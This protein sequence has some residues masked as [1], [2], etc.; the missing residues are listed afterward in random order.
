[1][2][3]ILELDR[4]N[5]TMPV[6]PR[7]ADCSA[8]LTLPP[9]QVCSIR[10]TPGS[11]KTFTIAG[12][13]AEN[14]CGLRGL[15][16]G[17][18]TAITSWKSSCRTAKSC[19]SATN[20]SA[21]AAGYSLKA[22]LFIG[23]KRRRHYHQGPSAIHLKS[24]ATKKTR[25]SPPSRNGSGCRSGFRHHRRANHPRYT[26]ISRSHHHPLLVEDYAK[27]GLPPDHGKRCCRCKRTVIRRLVAEEAARME[28]CCRACG[29]LEVRVA[30]DDAVP[31]AWQAPDVPCSSA[32]ARVAPTTILE[33]ATVPRSELARMIRFVADVSLPSSAS[34]HL[35]RYGH[36]NLHPTFQCMHCG[37]CL[38]T[39][40]TYDATKVERNSPR[41]RIS[42]M[43]AIADGR[44]ELHWQNCFLP[45]KCISA[46]GCLKP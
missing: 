29:C 8:S 25:W 33:D 15:K 36:G 40:P 23:P 16:Y 24:P 3:K 35:A 10:P 42:L 37:L 5:L 46:S 2:D 31:P 6:E 4:A 32:L 27:I 43:R 41:G 19:G 22:D 34:A 1:M 13:V 14:S 30:K 26:G 21:T 44:L 11:M 45:T 7:P 18:I 28:Q 39:C 9:K 20:A 17:V 38:P 12:N